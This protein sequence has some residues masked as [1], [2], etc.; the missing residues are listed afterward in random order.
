MV[1]L[2][3]KQMEQ[4]M[5]TTT[6]PVMVI[7]A[8]VAGIQAS[9][10]L[11][12]A[13]VPVILVERKGSIGGTMAALD[14]TFPTLDCSICIEAPLMNDVMNNPNIEVKTLTEVQKIEG[15]AGD[16]QVTLFEKQRY[17]TDACTRCNLCTDAC[18]Q[19]TLNEFD[20]GLAERTANPSSN[21]LRVV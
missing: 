10:D 11:A 17:V 2:Q 8:G 16:F 19:T 1:D 15:E 14:K 5:P 13:G 9:L 7:G 18:P 21:S 12:K 4:I 6:K 20:E 3:Q